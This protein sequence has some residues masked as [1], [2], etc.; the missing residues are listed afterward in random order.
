MEDVN[1]LLGDFWDDFNI[2]DFVV[3]QDTKNAKG[4]NILDDLEVEWPRYTRGVQKLFS[5]LLQVGA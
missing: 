1:D 4:I 2:L 3:G 5:G